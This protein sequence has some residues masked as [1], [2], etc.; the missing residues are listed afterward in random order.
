MNPTTLPDPITDDMVRLGY[1]ALSLLTDH[2][3]LA[4]VQR[5]GPAALLNLHHDPASV[6]LRARRALATAEGLGARA[7]LPGDPQW[8]AQLHDLPANAIPLC[9]WV[10]GPRM[11]PEATAQSV[12][13]TGSRAATAYGTHLAQQL[14]HDL[15]DRYGWTVASGAA[16]GIDAAALR[17][18]AV[19][20]HSMPPLIVSGSGLDNP[21]PTAHTD[22]YAYAAAEGLVVTAEPPGATLTRDRHHRR[23]QLAAALT[24]GVLIVETTTRGGAMTLAEHA[25]RMTRPVAAVPGPVTSTHSAGC[26]ALIRDRHA[27]LV[28]TAT[29][30]HDALTPR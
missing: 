8:P 11:L 6:L 22:L 14:A 13:V 2:T 10:Q 4:T 29:E 21:H 26:H 7:V 15:T 17:G 9:L 19:T 5:H 25:R 12:Y 28:G 30:A 16:F 1:V 27:R 23:L 20:R 3:N 18:A 24:S